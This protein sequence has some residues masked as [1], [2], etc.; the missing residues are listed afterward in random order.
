MKQEGKETRLAALAAEITLLESS[1]TVRLALKAREKRAAMEMRLAELRK[2]DREG[3][4]LSTMGITPETLD[5]LGGAGVEYGTD[6][7]GL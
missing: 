6:G 1:Y 3:R 7:E 4:D 2:L 5:A